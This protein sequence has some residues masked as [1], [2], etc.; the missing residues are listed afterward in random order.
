MKK[1]SYERWLPFVHQIR[2]VGVL[3]PFSDDQIKTIKDGW[4]DQRY[5][6]IDVWQQIEK[7]AKKTSSESQA[8]TAISMG[9]DYLLTKQSLSLLEGLIWSVATPPPEY[10]QNATANAANAEVQRFRAKSDA[11]GREM[12]LSTAE[13]QT[14]CLGFLLAALLETATSAQSS[15]TEE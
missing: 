15:D 4:H 5:T 2:I 9:R 3:R 6:R 12:R 14:E 11:R 7:S 10:L 8:Q 13:V 1:A